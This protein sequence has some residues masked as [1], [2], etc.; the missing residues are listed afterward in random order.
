MHPEVPEQGSRSSYQIPRSFDVSTSV[1]LYVFNIYSPVLTMLSSGTLP[2]EVVLMI[3]GY[4]EYA[5]DINSVA[6]TCRYLNRIATTP[7]LYP[8]FARLV[9]PQGLKRILLHRNSLALRKLFHSGVELDQLL[10][11]QHTEA[12]KALV[13]MLR[14]HENEA[15]LRSLPD[16]KDDLI[17]IA[18]E[19][20]DEAVLCA[21]KKVGLF[22]DAQRYHISWV[23]EKG[24]PASLRFLLNLGYGNPSAMFYAAA[25][26]QIDNIKLL[27]GSGLDSNVLIPSHGG[28]WPDSQT[29]V[30]VAAWHGHANVVK[31]LLECGAPENGTFRYSR[32]AKMVS[33]NYMQAAN[34]LMQPR[35]IEADI[36]DSDIK[37]RSDM[38]LY[39]VAV[40]NLALVR[41]LLDAG[42]FLHRRN[43]DHFYTDE[44]VQAI[45]IEDMDKDRDRC[46]FYI[47]GL[48]GQTAVLQHLLGQIPDPRGPKAACLSSIRGAIEGANLSTASIALEIGGPTLTKE[49][50]YAVLYNSVGERC[51]EVSS[52]LVG[53][54]VH[55]TIFRDEDLLEPV[56]RAG[57]FK[58]LWQMMDRGRIGPLDRIKGKRYSSIMHLAAGHAPVDIF[59]NL[60]RGITTG[61]THPFCADALLHATENLRVDVVEQFLDWG[62]DINELY[63]YTRLDSDTYKAPSSLFHIA[64]SNQ[65]RRNRENG[66]LCA[67]I[68]FLITHGLDVSKWDCLGDFYNVQFLMDR[69]WLQAPPPHDRHIAQ[70][71]LDAGVDPLHSRGEEKGSILQQVIL[72]GQYHY[73]HDLLRG[74]PLRYDPR[75]A[76]IWNRL[77]DWQKDEPPAQSGMQ[78]GWN[79]LIGHYEY[80]ARL[81]TTR[82]LTWHDCR[83]KDTLKIR[84]AI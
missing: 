17:H 67:F 5:A 59:Q 66:R 33:L 20:G 73:A 81:L 42:C 61:M 69:D 24:P 19:D 70:L 1:V 44:H 72:N 32:I 52:L 22:D 47:A 13:T 65:S 53:R 6:Q 68:R 31:F 58:L 37:S 75:L 76:Q 55:V 38:L 71:L 39:F 60:C 26:G 10:Y 50:E 51:H 8:G 63:S 28:Y 83:V 77:P 7:F 3:F 9:T 49:E 78:R 15:V 36:I 21:M 74:L 2:A 43:V 14:E 57:N 12:H 40:G 23:A 34:L 46:I 4:F 54:I 62:F 25:G 16:H 30:S 41:R 45:G 79:R 56:V 64:I 48:Y 35:D 80:W 11:Y 84:E 82:E 29:L 27:I 18:L